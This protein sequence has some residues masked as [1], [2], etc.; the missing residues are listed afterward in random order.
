MIRE[1]PT[2]QSPV[3]RN[4]QNGGGTPDQNEEHKSDQRYHSTES[5]RRRCEQPGRGE[6]FCH[7]ERSDDP[8]CAS[9][10]FLLVGCEV[11][12]AHG[13]EQRM[14]TIWTNQIRPHMDRVDPVCNKRIRSLTSGLSILSDGSE[15]DRRRFPG[16]DP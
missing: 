10:M 12:P 13:C 11:V 2:L 3:Y 6:P 7:H 15:P 8:D 1:E 4:L 16:P 5:R 9:A 14:W